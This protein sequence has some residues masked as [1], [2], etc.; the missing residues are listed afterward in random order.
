MGSACRIRDTGRTAT[1][2]NNL[3]IFSILN[4]YFSRYFGFTETEVREMLA[5][6]GLTEKYEDVRRWYDGY[7]FGETEIYNPWSII[8][9]VKLALEASPIALKPYWSNTSSNSIVRELVERADR[10]A[11]SEI[12]RLIEGGSIEKPIHEDITYEDIYQTQDNLWNFL[13]FTGYL[14]KTGARMEDDR[15]L[16]TLTIP[17]TE[18]RT[19]YK[20]TI[21]SWFDRRLKQKD[22]TPLYRAVEEGD[23]ETFAAS[24]NEQLRD[25]ISFFDYAENYYHGFLAGLLM[26]MQNFDVLSNREAGTGRADLIL[27]DG[28]LHGKAIVI[29][30]KAAKKISDM[31]TMCEDALRQI[32]EREYDSALADEGYDHILKYGVC[33]FRKGCIVR[34]A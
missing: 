34:K 28:I 31:E 10:Q 30:V 22:L 23:C 26:G 14:K 9:Y 8:N 33:F 29:E 17:N 19:I 25:T 4:P 32:E 5:Y 15:I 7:I 1:G 21:L 24:V 13:Y 6:Y 20:D 18:I 3:D 27:K 16:L 2:L 12:E 11:R